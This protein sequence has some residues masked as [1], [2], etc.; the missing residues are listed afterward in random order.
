MKI[1]IIGNGK[2]G[3]SVALEA[4]KRNH[5]I[6][7]VFDENNKQ[8]ITV[9]NLQMVDVV[10]E[11]TQPESAFENI[12]LCFD[13]D[14]PVVSG[15]TGWL[16]KLPEVKERCYTEGKT[17][18]YAP[19]FSIGMNIFM[20]VNEYLA[21]LMSVEEDYMAAISETHHTEKMDAP[22]G[23][24]VVLA[25]DILD[26]SERYGVWVKGKA[27]ADDELPVFSER[28]GDTT[29]IHTVKYES[30]LDFI[31]IKHHLKDR[32]SLAVG[33]VMAA[34]FTADKSGFLTMDDL[35]Q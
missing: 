1:A 10:M 33:A 11:F 2:M 25:R 19:N 34:E 7:F 24:A 8:Q 20:R 29:G 6:V 28:K 35:L 4:K 32:Q 26:M 17:L 9:N 30:D 23:T 15:T 5:E 22:S 16:E 12:N 27:Q 31:E 18:F 13:A 3:R 14:V 21:E